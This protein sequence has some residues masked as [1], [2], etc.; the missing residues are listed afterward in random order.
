MP[1]SIMFMFDIVILIMIS[2][3]G[4]CLFGAGPLSLLD[5]INQNERVVSWCTSYSC[6]MCAHFSLYIKR[7]FLSLDLE[8]LSL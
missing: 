6:G 3:L 7:V 8:S 5:D 2:S 1:I 4:V